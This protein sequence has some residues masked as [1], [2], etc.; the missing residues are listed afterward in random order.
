MS[1]MPGIFWQLRGDGVVQQAGDRE[2]LAVLQL[3][4]RLRAARR[5]G[6]HAEALEIETALA[7]SSELTSGAHLQLHQVAADDGRA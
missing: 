7:K 1:P 4:F 2:R 5:D 6:R 3:H